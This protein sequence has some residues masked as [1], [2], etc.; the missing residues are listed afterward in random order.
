[1][2][3]TRR[4]TDDE[5]YDLAMVAAASERRNRPKNLIVVPLLLFV[6]ASIMLIYGIFTLESGRVKLQSQESRVNKL[7]NNVVILKELEQTG[8]APGVEGI[9]DP[10]TDFLTR[11]ETYA[12]DAGL[13]KAPA[14]PATRRDRF[15][16]FVRVR[17]VYTNVVDPSLPALLQWVKITQD[18]IPGLFVY[19]LALK[20]AGDRGWTL[21]VTF[22]RWE[23]EGQS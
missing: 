6:I 1:M 22:A 20:P 8:D 12:T 9:L 23:R 4:L 17:Q 5:R 21:D 7:V 13:G 15:P 2:P 16:G 3:E 19:S 10:I 11:A 18:E 14:L